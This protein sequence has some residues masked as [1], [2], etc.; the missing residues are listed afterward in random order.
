MI[1]KKMAKGITRQINRELYSGYL[2]LAMSSY[3]Q[4]IGLQGVANWFYVQM[5]EEFSH[6]EKMYRYL[7]QQNV[8]AML[9]AIESP[10]QDFSSVKDLFKKTLEHEKQ[11]TSMINDLVVLAVEEKDMATGIML[12]WFVSEQVEEESNAGDM[13]R[14]LEIFG[15]KGDALLM[16]DRDLAQRVYSPP[17]TN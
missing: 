15:D 9:E 16:M 7:Q 12:Q 14:K 6:A 10:P 1:S 17:Q 3:A 13:L 4:D 2:Y 11:V 8:R 5:Q